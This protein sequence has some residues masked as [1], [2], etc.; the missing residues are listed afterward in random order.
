MPEGLRMIAEMEAERRKTAD[1]DPEAALS[2]QPGTE[3][4]DNGTVDCI[5]EWQR[6]R[7]SRPPRCR[8]ASREGWPRVQD[9]LGLETRGL[10]LTEAAQI[11][12]IPQPKVSLL[13]RGRFRDFSTDRLFRILNK[14]GV[15]VSLVLT[16]EPEGRAGTTTVVD[17]GKS[18]DEPARAVVEHAMAAHGG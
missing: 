14:P 13:V 2:L 1:G 11:I 7:G 3:E 17:R 5:R 10:T 9:R 4:N 15:T 18:A 6:F 8:G 12:G 16:E